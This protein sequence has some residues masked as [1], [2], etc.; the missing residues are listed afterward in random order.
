MNKGLAEFVGVFIGDGC[1]SQ[2]ARKDRTDLAKTVLLTGSWNNDFRYYEKIIKPVVESKFGKC[3]RIYHRK[4]DNTIRFFINGKGIIRFLQSLGF[5]FGP[6]SMDVSIPNKILKD[7]KFT[8]ACLRGIFNAD[9]SIYNR[10]SKAYKGHN[11]IYSDYKVIQIKSNSKLLIQQVK[12]I[13]NNNS[14]R[15]NKIII[16]RE[17]YVIRVTNQ[18]EIAKFISTVGMNHP[19]H[20]ERMKMGPTGFE[21]A[22]PSPKL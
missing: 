22:T 9:G 10:Y 6:K 12:I 19:H 13:L 14:I 16:D 20:L 4:D 8:I 18:K 15:S 1:M 11:R 7:N 5:K 17:A 2:W 21:P 3:T